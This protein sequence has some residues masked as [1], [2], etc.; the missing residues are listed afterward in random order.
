MKKLI[1]I[2]LVLCTS[3][4]VLNGA[5]PNISDALKEL[6]LPREIKK[7]ENKPLVEVQGVEKYKPM[8]KDDKSGRKVLIKDFKITNNSEISSK[9]L[10]SLIE[11]S[12]DKRLNFS[13]M[14]NLAFKISKYYQDQGFFVARAY[15]PVQNMKDNVLE[16]S[17]IEGLYGEFKLINN[18]KIKDK[19]LKEIIK[20]K[21]DEI[22]H[23]DS[24]E[25]RL[26]LL[27]ELH[28][29]VVSNAKVQA[30]KDVGT[31]DFVLTIEDTKAYDG[32]IVTDNYGSRYTGKNRLLAGVNF[33][34]PFKIGDKLSLSALLSN[35]E[36]LKSGS[37]SYSFPLLGTGLNS[38]ISFSKT[39]Y[40]LEEEYKDLD[41]RGTSNELSLK[42]SYH[43]IKKRDESLEVYTQFSFKKLKDE[44]LSKDYESN[45]RAYVS[46]VGFNYEKT[47]LNFLDV[48]HSLNISSYINYGYLRF[49][50][51]E[52]RQL[53]RE[54]ADTQGSFS[55]LYSELS[56][57][58]YINENFFIESL[59]KYQHALGNKNLDGSEDFSLGG[60]YGVKVYP[61]S[62]HSAENGYLF[63]I[64][65][66]YHLP[67]IENYSH[68]L[69]VF[70]DRGRA[71]M[72]NPLAS[73]ESRTLQD[74]GLGYYANYKDFFTKAQIAW[75]VDNEEL[76]SEPSQNSKFL[77]MLG[78][79]F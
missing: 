44:V 45:K 18:S 39:Y 38:E 71:Y 49:E 28:G 29:V 50:D 24:F 73:F 51:E 48:N 74:V 34:N 53:D 56:L 23:N 75:R 68:T 52:L 2:S 35:K 1:N 15:I 14:Q 46:S 12:K 10:L 76:T 58:S 33:N 19:N 4:S 8:L 11:D 64:E 9:K 69:G 77:F 70:Y 17:V 42:L 47:N 25:R 27:N 57:T 7:L 32:Y 62:E 65:A 30:G 26:L 79:R 54:G 21:K 59:F 5:Q 40:N 6:E 36:D 31:S 41:S 20:V 78:W 22:I 43:Y 63:L 72:Q 16:I 66:K 3:L 55:K 61:S 60:A 67:S 13:Q 37:L